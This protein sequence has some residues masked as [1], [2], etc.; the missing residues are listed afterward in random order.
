MSGNLRGRAA[1]VLVI[2]GVV[3]LGLAALGPSVSAAN[4]ALSGWTPQGGAAGWQVQPA[5]DSVYVVAPNPDFPHSNGSPSFF[6]SPFNAASTF[7]VHIRPNNEADD[8]Y[9]GFALGY[10][11]P[12]NDSAC[13]SAASCDT[14]FYLFDWKKAQ[15]LEGGTATADGHE[16]FSLMHV[17]GQHDMRN[18]NTP[19]HI[20][21]F[22]THQDVANACDV[23]GTDF[24]A[25]KGYAFG[26][27]YTFQVTYTAS[28]LKVVLLANGANP[29]RTIFDVAPPGGTT[30]PAGRVAFYNY[31]QPEVEYGFD[32][33]NAPNPTTTT[34][35]TAAVTSTTARSTGT[36]TAPTV[37]P[38]VSSSI[39]RTGPNS[40]ATTI[41]LTAGLLLLLA[42]AGMTAARG[43]RPEG[44]FYA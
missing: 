4:A 23:L 30:F 26:T 14:G 5:G 25:G 44:R 16:G 24:G 42:G 3:L 10:T 19:D 38:A 27:T 20:N 28:Q 9:V 11:K 7:Y 2:A 43:K 41:E 18:N 22:W 34:T 1:G 37:G 33:T 6:V 35:T 13:Q 17:Q 15:E 8:D 31:S 39:V 40:L 29:D 36:T 32:L 12:L 21:C